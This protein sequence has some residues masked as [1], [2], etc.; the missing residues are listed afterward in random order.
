MLCHL[1]RRDPV[2]LLD[3]LAGVGGS[4]LIVA[5][6]PEPFYLRVPRR[7]EETG[8]APVVVSS[9]LTHPLASLHSCDCTNFL[10]QECNKQGLLS[11]VDFASL[12]GKRYVGGP[13]GC[14]SLPLCSLSC[15]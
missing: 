8:Q 11:E 7:R 9:L 2:F 14:L 15:K 3:Y 10:L 13:L 1:S 4:G 5:K 6:Y 12:V